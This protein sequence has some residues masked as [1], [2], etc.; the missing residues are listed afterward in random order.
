MTFQSTIKNDS[1]FQQFTCRICGKGFC[2][3]FDLKKHTRKLHGDAHQQQTPSSSA[4]VAANGAVLAAN[5]NSSFS[6]ND[7]ERSSLGSSNGA[8]PVHQQQA[9]SIVKTSPSVVESVMPPHQTNANRMA[10]VSGVANKTMAS[11]NK[12]HHPSSAAMTPLAA[13]LRS[14]H[15]HLYHNSSPPGTMPPL[16]L[17]SSYHH[18]HQTHLM[19]TGGS[20]VNSTASS[21]RMPTGGA[22]TTAPSRLFQISSLL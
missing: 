15:Q 11:K 4:M 5:M 3:N 21:N 9:R 20:A 13:S 22:T 1:F 12:L 16:S 10:R 19:S 7:G 17:A 18:H 2:R 14:L 8:S 6:S